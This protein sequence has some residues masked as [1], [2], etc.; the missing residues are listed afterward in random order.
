MSFPSRKAAVVG[1]Y[2]SKQ[3]KNLPYA[4]PWSLEL[5]CIQGALADAGLTHK[6]VDG[7]IPMSFNTPLSLHM[8][9]AEQLGGRPISFLDVGGGAGA[10]SKAALG[11]AS[12]M[13]NVVVI[14]FGNAGVRLGPQGN[15]VNPSAP[16]VGD[17]SYTIQGA[18]MS[19]WYA[20]WTRRYMSQ[21]NVPAE[22]LAEYSVIARHHAVLNPESV[23]GVK[24]EITVD[25]VFNSRMIADPL[26]LLEC[27]LDNDGGY[28]IVVASET[29]AK[30]C[31]KAPIWILG[32]AEAVYTDPY[33][34]ITPDWISNEAQAVRTTADKAF[35]MAGVSRD[36]IDTAGLYDCFPVTMARDLEEV[37]FCKLGEGAAYIREGHVA[38]GGK[39]PCNTDGGLLSGS[40]NGNPSGMQIT[41]VTKQ[42]RGECGVRQVPN[43]K[44]G[45]ALS[46]GWAVHGLAG[47]V[48]LAAD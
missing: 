11:V 41:E 37:G 1:V 29:V 3:G 43:A 42:L 4:S 7:L 10:V 47:T 5:E 28:A 13:A 30:S 23:M 44:I 34:T 45:L 22:W 17:M 20:M 2:N 33:Q 18:Y 9:W 26:H 14:F 38:L 25:D 19:P 16:R 39:M 48:I 31:K 12:G 27:P 15:S 35:A 36:D 32:G 24:G 46:Q 21:F 40:H 6:D 8:Q